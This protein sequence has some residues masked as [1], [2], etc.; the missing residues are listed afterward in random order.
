MAILRDLAALKAGAFI[1]GVDEDYE[2]SDSDE[3]Y[4][5]EAEEE[6]VAPAP[7]PNRKKAVAQATVVSPPPN[8]PPAR[9]ISSSASTL[10]AAM[11]SLAVSSSTKLAI[12]KSSGGS[13]G[14]GTKLKKKNDP[15][16][17]AAKGKAVADLE[18]STVTSGFLWKVGGSG[19][20]MKHWKRRF[21]VLTDD[22]C[23]YYF[24]SP[25]DMSALGLILLPS[26][27]VT[28]ATGKEAVGGR[29]FAFKCFN[30]LKR[31]DRQFI[32]AADTAEEMK[33]WMNV[34]S[35]AC[36]AFGT[37]KASMAKSANGTDTEQVLSTSDD[38]ELHRMQERAQA[39]AGGVS[40]D[41]KPVSKPSQST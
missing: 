30:R 12:K 27:T 5:F 24:K 32:F 19:L 10:P 9:N 18:S 2:P 25:K 6:A 31:R 28:V 39:R 13:T 1:G 34:L 33:V 11:A 16:R 17:I 22:N 14:N 20:K 15:L 38:H 40:G 3:D 23:L 35:L 26:Y 36:I 8:S 41:T 4:D 29:Q 7:A 37:G 21:F